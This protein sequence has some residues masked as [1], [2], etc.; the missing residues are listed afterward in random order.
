MPINKPTPKRVPINQLSRHCPLCHSPMRGKAQVLEW[1]DVV[2]VGCTKCKLY[3]VEGDT[4]TFDRGQLGDEELDVKLRERA[5]VM[6]RTVHQGQNR[7]LD[8]KLL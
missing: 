7:C 6:L 2:V 5:L 4:M 8:W 3:G 1:F